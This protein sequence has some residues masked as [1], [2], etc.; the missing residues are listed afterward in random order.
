MYHSITRLVNCNHLVFAVQ[1]S[2]LLP[3]RMQTKG[4]PLL[5]ILFSY[6]IPGN[7]RVAFLAYRWSPFQ[8]GSLAPCQC[9]RFPG[10]F[11]SI[12]S[13]SDHG[14][15][16]R[17]CFLLKNHCSLLVNLLTACTA[18]AQ[19]RGWGESRHHPW[20]LRVSWLCFLK[21]NLHVI[22]TKI[23]NHTGYGSVERSFELLSNVIMKCSYPV[24]AECFWMPEMCLAVSSTRGSSTRQN[25]NKRSSQKQHDQ[26]FI[27]LWEKILH[28]VLSK[29]AL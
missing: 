11:T 13:P 5:F 24:T 16:Q 4:L 12:C 27:V 18:Q 14:F 29:N 7:S 10:G 1:S 19:L 26:F 2:G 21:G 25:K 3:L 9:L 28:A 6:T 20:M 15:V 23:N 8:C 22:Q 17:R